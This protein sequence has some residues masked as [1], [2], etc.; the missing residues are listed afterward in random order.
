MYKNFDIWMKDYKAGSIH[1]QISCHPSYWKILNLHNS[2]I[3]TNILS[4]LYWEKRNK[5]FSI[6]GGKL[7]GTLM[8]VHKI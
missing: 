7:S 3:K 4:S 8:Q 5:Y 1:D 6:E 2:D